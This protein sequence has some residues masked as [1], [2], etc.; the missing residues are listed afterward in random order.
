MGIFFCGFREEQGYWIPLPDLLQPEQRTATV[1]RPIS[2][3]IH[4]KVWKKFENQLFSAIRESGGHNP[5]Q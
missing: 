1:D 2:E 5:H 3:E 4:D